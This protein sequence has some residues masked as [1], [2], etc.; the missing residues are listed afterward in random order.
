MHYEHFKVIDST[1]NYLKNN[2]TALLRKDREIL[3][4][5]D[6]QNNGVGRQGNRWIHFENSIAFSFTLTPQKNIP[7]TSLELAVLI[8]I[9]FEE[10]QKIELILKWPNDLFSS[11]FK[12]CGGI[13]CN[14]HSKDIIIAGVGI[15]LTKPNMINKYDFNPGFISKKNISQNL[16]KKIYEYI[17][18]NRLSEYEIKKIWN[19][20]CFHLNQDVTI[21][22]GENHN[23]ITGNFIGI[24]NNGE[25]VIKQSSNEIIN[26]MSGN[27]SIHPLRSFKT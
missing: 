4:S 26:I 3:I 1:Q 11:S 16:S 23:L 17:L 22:Q 10:K 5:T 20:K 2:I 18:T 6:K 12:K 21:T 8:A 7:L 19:E 25:A 9:F 14:Y 27:L 15:N 13:I 24:G